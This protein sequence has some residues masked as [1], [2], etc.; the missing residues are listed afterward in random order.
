[1][2][3]AEAVLRANGG[4]RYLNSSGNGRNSS[5]GYKSGGT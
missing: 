3:Q 2:N 4:G 1:M 5:P